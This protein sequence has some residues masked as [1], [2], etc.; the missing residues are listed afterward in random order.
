MCSSDLASTSQLLNVRSRMWSAELIDDLKLPKNIY[1]EI[2]SSGKTIGELDKEIAED[3]EIA[4]M[5]VIAVCGHDTQS[6]M[7]AV[8]NRDKDYLFISC[9]TWSLIGTELFGRGAALYQKLSR[10]ITQADRV[11]RYAETIC[12]TYTRSSVDRK[13]VV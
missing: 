13:S 2:I 4:P 9:G 5:K 12:R 10:L 7:V 8:P 1:P 3:L 11:F 6:A